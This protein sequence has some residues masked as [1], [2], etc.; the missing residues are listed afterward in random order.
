MPGNIIKIMVEEGQQVAKNDVLMVMS[1]MKT[2]TLIHSP[3][4]GKIKELIVKEGS[5]VD[6]NDLIVIL[7]P[8]ESK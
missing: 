2:E 7:E 3:T 4:G 1:V 8:E 5:S 6:H